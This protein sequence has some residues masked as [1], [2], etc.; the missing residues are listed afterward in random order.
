MYDGSGSKKTIL[1]RLG[2]R[3]RMPA[4]WKPPAPAWSAVFDTPSGLLVI[5][6]MATQLRAG[7]APEHLERM[8]A[9]CA[10]TDGPDNLEV[11]RFIDRAGIHTIVSIGYWT[12]P[13]RY[14]S[15]Q[16]RSGFA[17]WWNDPARAR[18]ANGYFREVLTVPTDRIETIFGSPEVAGAAKTMRTIRGPVQEHNYW[19]SM[20]H[21]LPVAAY[22]DLVSG[23]GESLPRLGEAVT[24]RRRLRVSA[25]ENLAVI[26]SGQDWSRC[27]EEERA[28]YE[29]S[30]RPALVKGM[31]FLRD[32]P[33]ETGCCDM[34]LAQEINARGE[35]L[36]KSF[37]H[38]LFLSLGHLE[39]WSAT[40]PTHHAI[41]ARFAG[42]VRQ[43]RFK[44]DLRLWHEVSVLPGAGQVF[45][46]V[47][48]H[49][50]TGLLPY[51]PAEE[52]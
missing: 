22:N 26:R 8:N 24:E 38:G 7:A 47:N 41:F 4:D 43:R 5:A 51:F 32:H 27:D 14:D 39:R 11:A 52:F 44:F 45:E 30:V 50:R 21:R 15:W 28:I 25:P 36:R 40:H 13:A 3:E 2:A 34:R 6:Y 35:E 18:E 17:A 9:F 37:G 12:S 29:G 48:C 31:D 16:A 33:E 10:F 42:L 20:R 19:G 23:Y 1:P 46:Y 49:N